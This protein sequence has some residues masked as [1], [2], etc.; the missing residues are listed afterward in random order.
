MVTHKA[1]IQVP[2]TEANHIQGLLDGSAPTRDKN[3][4]TYTAHFANG[5]EADIKVVQDADSPYLDPVL[6]DNQ[7]HELACLQDDS[8][9][10]DGIYHF[11]VG[12]DI[13]LVEVSVAS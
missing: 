3:T 9:R 10:I 4:L 1:S 6:F 2:V 11:E 5:Y 12:E 13:Y 7:G 8:Y